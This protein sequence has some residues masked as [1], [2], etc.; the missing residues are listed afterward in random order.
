MSK[1]GCTTWENILQRDYKA[2]RGRQTTYLVNR[3]YPPERDASFKRFLNI[4]HPFDRL[5]SAFY[6][7]KRKKKPYERGPGMPQ[8]NHILKKYGT[9][10]EALKFSQF[11][12]FVASSDQGQ[13]GGVYYDRHWDAYSRS[14]RTCSETYTFVTRTETSE[15]DSGPILKIVEYPED[16]LS[17]AKQQNHISRPSDTKNSSVVTPKPP[18][19]GKYL[20][21]F[22]S[23]DPELVL[24]LYE[25]YQG[26]FEGF[27]YHFDTKTNMA[28]CSIKTENGDYCC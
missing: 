24:R 19:F 21:E 2:K 10:Q 26:D 8:I 17:K 28:Y 5:L 6:N 4:R 16:Y 27:G 22:N 25:R 3:R 13:P 14:C 18:Q 1:A 15:K 12:E 23:I 20:S 9:T 11:A 7:V